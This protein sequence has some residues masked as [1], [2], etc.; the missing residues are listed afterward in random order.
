MS[1]VYV[2]LT[3]PMFCRVFSHNRVIFFR[4]CH[5]HGASACL[6]L[7]GT[8]QHPSHT[9]PPDLPPP[10]KGALSRPRE[11]IGRQEGTAPQRR[12]KGAREIQSRPRSAA[13]EGDPVP[14]FQPWAPARSPRYVACGPAARLLFAAPRRLHNGSRP[15]LHCAPKSGHSPPNPPPR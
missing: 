6:T 12:P 14:S 8:G 10:V 3:E 4:I 5:P 15:C 2:Y 9:L 1:N 11:R 7:N 13:P